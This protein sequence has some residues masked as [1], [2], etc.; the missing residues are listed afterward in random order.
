MLK[1][2]K[3]VGL[4]ELEKFGFVSPFSKN[5]LY[6]KPFYHH[7]INRRRIIIMPLF[8]IVICDD[9]EISFEGNMYYGQYEEFYNDTLFD[10]LKADL[11]EKVGD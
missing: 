10:L 6:I 4:K 11:I 5:Y 3:N 9:R 7:T 8:W 1:I 2:K